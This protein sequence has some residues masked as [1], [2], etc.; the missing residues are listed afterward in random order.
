MGVV[1][2]DDHVAL[3]DEVL[4][5]GDRV[6]PEA[7][8]AVAVDHQREPAL[9]DGGARVRVGVGVTG[10][11]EEEPGKPVPAGQ[12]RAHVVV[13]RLPSQ[14][15]GVFLDVGRVPDLHVDLPPPAGVLS[16]FVDELGMAEGQRLGAD[17]ERPGRD[18]QLRHRKQE[19]RRDREEQAERTEQE[20][21]HPPGPRQL[22]LNRHHVADRHPHRHHVQEEQRP[23]VALDLPL[24][25]DQPDEDRR[26]HPASGPHPE[27][28]R[29]DDADGAGDDQIRLE[30]SHRPA[31]VPGSK[32]YGSSSRLAA[33]RAA[34]ERSSAVGPS[35]AT[36]PPLRTIDLGQRRRARGRSWVTMS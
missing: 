9:V 35:A 2:G 5:L 32:P 16:P 8:P 21:P 14:R 11:V 15:D 34:S 19:R 23:P 33:I 24:E 4:H 10:R 1:D 31:I 30:G 26:H 25:D 12:R 7:L 13:L 20:P 36:R 3:A 29:P 27:Q 17:L 22:P 28:R 6:R 18:R